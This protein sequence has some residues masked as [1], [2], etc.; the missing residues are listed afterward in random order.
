MDI[1]RQVIMDHFKHPQNKVDENFF[2]ENY[3]CK[4]GL[5]PSCGDDVTLYIKIE[6]NTIT[7]LKFKGTGCSICCSS[8][9]VLTLEL[10]NMLLIDAKNKISKFSQL[11]NDGEINEEIFEDAN[12]FSGIK[13]YPARFKCANISW[14]TAM[15][16]LE[17]LKNE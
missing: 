2:S 7:D 12:A 13:E 5:N 9:S 14:Q 10:Q 11:L 16:I 8:A 4:Q 3:I 15:D 6:N 1:Y 17:E